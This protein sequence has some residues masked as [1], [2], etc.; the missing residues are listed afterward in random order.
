MQRSVEKVHVEKDLENYIV[1][2]VS[3]TREHHAIEV[4][5]SP[6]GSLAMLKLAKAHAWV[7]QRN[8]VVPDDVKAVAVFA[9][10]HRLILTADQWIRGTKAESLVADI[11]SRVPV[12]KVVVASSS[13]QATPRG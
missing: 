9:L 7:D 5:S 11:L 2:I 8:Y 10:S 1:E 4:G 13:S 3:R 6:R 12:P